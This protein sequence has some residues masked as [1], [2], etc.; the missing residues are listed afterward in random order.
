MTTVDDLMRWF[1]E[2]A[3]QHGSVRL[4]NAYRGIPV[5]HPATVQSVSQGY[6]VVEVHPLQAACMNIE[7]RTFMLVDIIPYALRARVVAVEM[8]RSQAI[9]AEFARTSA[10]IGKRLTV[11]VQPR[12]P[13]EAQ[14]YDGEL[15]VPGKLADIST[16]GAGISELNT[17]IYG[18]VQ[19]QKGQQVTLDVRLPNREPVMRFKAR[20]TNLVSSPETPLYRVGMTISADPLTIGALQEYIEARQEETIEELQQVY[21]SLCRQQATR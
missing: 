8:L 18:A 9:L 13:I 16:T 14:I 17:H 1:Q 19:W 20:I 3:A 11:R 4:L 6:V 12:R 21:G 10:S 2:M 5:I 15:R 7:G